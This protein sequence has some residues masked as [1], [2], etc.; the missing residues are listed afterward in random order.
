MKGEIRN[1]YLFAPYIKVD[2]KGPYEP[3]ILMI[4][5]NSSVPC[6]GYTYETWYAEA[7]KIRVPVENPESQFAIMTELMYKTRLGG[8]QV[9]GKTISPRDSIWGGD[10]GFAIG[11][12]SE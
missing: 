9:I 6:S 11:Y 1:S 12:F 4:Y 7:V 3:G 2:S 8:F 5:L 10:V